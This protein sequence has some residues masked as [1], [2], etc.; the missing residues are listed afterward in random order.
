MPITGTPG[1]LHS[2][3]MLWLW[4]IINAVKLKTSESLQPFSTQQWTV[5]KCDCVS[6]LSLQLSQLFPDECLEK[7]LP[8]IPG[9]DSTHELDP[10]YFCFWILT[11]NAQTDTLILIYTMFFFLSGMGYKFNIYNTFADRSFLK[12]SCKKRHFLCIKRASK[13]ICVEIL[14]FIILY[15]Y[16]LKCSL[17]K[18]T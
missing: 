11:R 6:V 4:R 17:N 8:Q 1:K 15:C 10:R 13:N 5:K 18:I 3:K 16:K 9:L 14:L 12:C 7:L 2:R